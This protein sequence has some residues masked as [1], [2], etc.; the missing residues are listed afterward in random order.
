MNE[1]YYSQTPSSQRDV[2]LHEVEAAG[3]AIKAYT[4]A[5]V[6][7]K[8]GLDYGSRLLVESIPEASGRVLDL[9]CGWGAIGIIL[10]KAFPGIS[11]TMSDVNARAVEL[12]RRNCALNGVDAR[13]VE[14]DGMA[15]IEGTFDL[16]AL[17]PPIRAGKKTVYDLF[18]QC[19]ERLDAGGKLYI[20]IRKQQGAESAFKYLETLFASVRR[21]NRDK[22]YWIILCEKDETNET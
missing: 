13:A 15:K 3:V 7:S 2:R 5:G 6:F 18:G 1:F 14:S 12:A 10:A 8:E 16:I 20:V 21:V 19:F 17:N 11:L 22:G 4:D 9:G